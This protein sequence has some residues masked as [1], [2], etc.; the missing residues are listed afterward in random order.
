MNKF[1]MFSGA[2][3]PI[4]DR[5]ILDALRGSDI[6]KKA[7]AERDSSVLAFRKAAVAKLAKLKAD[8]D[9]RFPKLRAEFEAARDDA[10]AAEIAWRQKADRACEIQS[11]LSADS[12]TFT[13]DVAKAEAHL[14][15]TASPEILPFI[16]DM[17]SLWED[18][19]KQIATREVAET[20]VRLLDRTKI[21]QVSNRT[22]VLARREA[23]RDAIEAAENMRLEPDQST[24]SARL[25]ELRHN[26]PAIEKV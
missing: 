22:S 24:V 13:N 8:A 10:R 26:L 16:A 9:G 12:A 17:W 15:E 2:A 4:D 6:V 7:T 20:S 19:A 18:A 23:I 25:Q 1:P 14:A 5:G 21:L 3:V 11:K